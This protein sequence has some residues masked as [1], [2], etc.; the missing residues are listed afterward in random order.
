[1]NTARKLRYLSDIDYLAGEQTSDVK[2]E[3]VGGV[4]YAMVGA[5]NVHNVIAGNIF[6]S[7]HH[8]LRS[9]PCRPYNSD[10]KIRV[11]LPTETRFYYPDV[12]VT[13]HP[14]PQSDT[15]QDHPNVIVE[16]LSDNTRRID[17][18]EKKDA[19]LTLTSLTAYLL[20]EQDIQHVTIYRRGAEGFESEEYTDSDAVIRL[21]DIRAALSMSDIYD[22]VRF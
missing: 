2:H 12:S 5:R 13:C 20:V 14:N 7:L 3:Y 1:M 9:G 6:A 17:D 22:G 21:D 10:T 4:V 16:V 19:Y 11:Q 15:F 18:G 8:S